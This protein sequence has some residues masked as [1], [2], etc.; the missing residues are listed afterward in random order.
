MQL[1]GLNVQNALMAIGCGPTGLLDDE[2]KWTRLVEK[3]E[4]PV[5]V[6]AIGGVGEEAAAKEI[7]MEVGDE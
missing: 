3:A 5:S 7:A 4:L 6:P 1:S 2:C